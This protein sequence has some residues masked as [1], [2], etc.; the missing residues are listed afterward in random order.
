MPEDV[1]YLIRL[2]HSNMGWREKV[3]Y[4][5]NNMNYLNEGNVSSGQTAV[6]CVTGRAQRKGRHKGVDQW[7]FQLQ[8][9][10]Y[11]EVGRTTV[12]VVSGSLLPAL[13]GLTSQISLVGDSHGAESA[14][15]QWDFVCV[16][17]LHL[18]FRNT[19]DNK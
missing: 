19:P 12:Q 11:L 14:A 15:S 6:I 16:G 2:K 10:Q 17:C 3:R 8:G 4:C 9:R 13:P 5:K 7:C 18:K 1:S